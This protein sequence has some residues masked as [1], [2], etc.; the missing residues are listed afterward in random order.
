MN[1][2]IIE[3]KSQNPLRFKKYESIACQGNGYMGVRNSL[4]EEYIYS[5]RNTFI[6]GVFNAPAGEVSELASLPDVTNF[7]IF[8]DGERFFL[9]ETKVSNYSRFLNMQCVKF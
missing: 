1:E 2:W 5:H 9:D 8:V 3:E 4:E 6:N 7:E